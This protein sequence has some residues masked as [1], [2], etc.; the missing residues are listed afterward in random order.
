MA[1]NDDD[2]SL[3]NNFV[4]LLNY[5]R[6]DVARL[7]TNVLKRQ[8]GDV[9]GL[10]GSDMFE[11]LENENKVE[12]SKCSNFVVF[13]FSV[14][15]DVLLK[16]NNHELNGNQPFYNDVS[17]LKDIWNTKITDNKD[18]KISSDFMQTFKNHIDEMSHRMIRKFGEEFVLKKIKFDHSFGKLS[19]L[20]H[21]II[22][23]GRLIISLYGVYI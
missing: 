5:L 9:N 14:L 16:G 20:K 19:Y 4:I 6:N 15:C 11:S 3:R 17:Y 10:K 21:T 23:S 13:P 2:Y 22:I 8:Y 1:D 7:L 18:E 12:I